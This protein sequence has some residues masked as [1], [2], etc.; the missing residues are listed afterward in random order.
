MTKIQN[1]YIIF[2]IHIIFCLSC[3]RKS[4]DSDQDT[5]DQQNLHHQQ[6]HSIE[7]VGSL[8]TG[9]NDLATE[10]VNQDGDRIHSLNSKPNSTKFRNRNSNPTPKKPKFVPLEKINL[11][12]PQEIEKLIKNKNIDINE[13][14]YEHDGYNLL[15]IATTKS[16]PNETIDILK[17][18]NLKHSNTY[19]IEKLMS[20]VKDKEYSK[21]ENLINEDLINI[22]NSNL[23]EKEIIHDNIIVNI[24]RNSENNTEEKIK[25]I[26]YLLEHKKIKDKFLKNK[27]LMQSL[28]IS[29]IRK[30]D[31]KIYKLFKDKYK[32]KFD[33]QSN[34]NSYSYSY[35]HL[36]I[37]AS[38]GGNIEILKE[39]VSAYKK[40][41]ISFD[42]NKLPSNYP[43]DSALSRAVSGSISDS[44]HDRRS[45]IEVAKY[46]I[47]K[48]GAEVSPEAFNEACR[49]AFK[50]MIKLLIKNNG[51]ILKKSKYDGRNALHALAASTIDSAKGDLIDC[52]KLLLNASSNK[53][54]YINT[55]DKQNRTP[56]YWACR[57]GNDE[58]ADFLLENEADIETGD[59][60]I[61]S[62]GYYSRT[63]ILNVFIKNNI[64]LNNNRLLQNASRNPHNMAIGEDEYIFF[65]TA[66]EKGG[67]R[68]I[69]YLDEY[70]NTILHNLFN[71]YNKYIERLNKVPYEQRIKHKWPTGKDCSN[72]LIKVIKLLKKHNYNFNAPTRGITL[73][74]LSKKLKLPTKIIN[75]MKNIT[76]I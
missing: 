45:T 70:D 23:K 44:I 6:L 34:S 38:S 26:N 65:K 18:N 15:D 9:K 19:V 66:L 68:D 33:L 52:A 2:I 49:W 39:V 5:F 20:S 57:Y 58:L 61:W 48:L 46:L 21:L 43:R 16:S 7:P 74:E 13:K 73:L 32:V 60:P 1:Y 53:I 27:I 37:L 72:Y 41:N 10:I 24:I 55:T 51:N 56:F 71:N 62:I 8:H 28:L 17:K 25:A 30:G 3:K 67:I 50:D 64:S 29:S 47:E 59:S 36:I 75:E 69:N 14:Y 42:I 35:P 12:N 54:D 11:N 63:N 76:T 40:Q 4:S 22:D 31:S